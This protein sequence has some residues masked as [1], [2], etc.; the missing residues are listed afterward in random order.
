M[1]SYYLHHS[2]ESRTKLLVYL[3]TV[4]GAE[5]RLPTRL[6]KIPPHFSVLADRR[7]YHGSILYHNFNAMICPHFLNSRNQFSSGEVQVEIPLCRLRY[8]S[9][10]GFAMFALEEGAANEISYQIFR[11]VHH[12]LHWAYAN[13]NIHQPLRKPVDYDTYPLIDEAFDPLQYV[14]VSLWFNSF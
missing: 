2:R 9:E 5:A 1:Q 7:F 10:V 11:I 12:I 6:A 4:E 14:I 3:S 8:T 13:I